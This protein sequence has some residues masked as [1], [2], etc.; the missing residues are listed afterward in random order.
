MRLLSLFCP[1]FALT[2]ALNHGHLS[3]LFEYQEMSDLFTCI[4]ASYDLYLEEAASCNTTH[5]IGLKMVTSTIRTV[6]MT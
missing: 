1:V 5:P 3:I 4:F 2:I 6:G